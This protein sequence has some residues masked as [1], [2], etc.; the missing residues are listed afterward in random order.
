M[1]LYITCTN[2]ISSRKVDH[3]FFFNKNKELI[4]SVNKKEVV[5]NSNNDSSKLDSFK[6]IVEYASSKNINTYEI[7]VENGN[8]L[9]DIVV[10]LTNYILDKELSIGLITMD[11]E[12]INGHIDFLEENGVALLNPFICYSPSYISEPDF[13]VTKLANKVEN[14]GA[15]R[16]IAKPAHIVLEESFHDKF[17]KLLIESG[18][19][20]AT[21]YKRAGVSRQ[22][23]SKIISNK[24]MIPTKLT[25]IS[26]C[27]GLELTYPEA[28]ELLE[29]AGYSLSK[30]IMFDS[31]IIKFLKAETYDYFLINSELD[32]YGC[33]LLGW[34]PRED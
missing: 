23:F 33:P 15:F 16:A 30:S 6:S 4:D 5:I 19:D 24:D 14:K 18:E 3:I 31:I 8:P 32:E 2:K 9:E 12:L 11:Q 13:Y 25:I 7:L 10:F 22:V 20:N 21:I 27:I 26:L 29:S 28:M 17:M 34:H 1:G